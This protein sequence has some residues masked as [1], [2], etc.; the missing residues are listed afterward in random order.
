MEFKKKKDKQGPRNESLGALFDG[1]NSIRTS[2]HVYK[3]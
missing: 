2:Q 1:P 3:H